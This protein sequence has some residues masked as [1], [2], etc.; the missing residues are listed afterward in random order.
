MAAPILRRRAEY[1][2]WILSILS[3]CIVTLGNFALWPPP[4]TA[5]LRRAPRAYFEP[6]TC[7]ISV[8]VNEWENG[9]SVTKRDHIWC[10][11]KLFDDMLVLREIS[12][13]LKYFLL[14]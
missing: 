6:K 8:T 5:L 9:C 12:I 14:I 2:G 13:K 4:Y 10:D 11:V 7:S 1:G 3:S